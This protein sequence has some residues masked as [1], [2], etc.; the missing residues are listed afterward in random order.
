MFIAVLTYKKSLA[1]ID[2]LIQKH[3]EFLEEHYA[4]GVFLCSGRRVPRTGGIIL[5]RTST[6]TE[7]E[8]IL[9]QDPFYTEHAATFEIFEFTP[10]K[11]NPIFNSIIN[12]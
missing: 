6:Q 7:L 1:E 8:D 2:L 11:W 3:V 5:A 9:Q 12:K 10:T 4:S